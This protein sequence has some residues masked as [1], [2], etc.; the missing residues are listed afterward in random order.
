M[1]LDTLKAQ[2]LSARKQKDAAHTAVLG[3]VIGDVETLAK[4]KPGTDPAVLIAG[5]L[6][7][8]LTALVREREQLAGLGRDTASIDLELP[9]LQQL[10]AQATEAQRQAQA[11]LSAR[12][13]SP[14]ALETAIRIAVTQGAGSIG[15]VM[16][17]LKTQHEGAYDG[18]LASD[19][20]RRVLAEANAAE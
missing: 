11:D 19:T 9:V 17:F 5:V 2:H 13:L 15:A 16:Q 18:K 14:E 10:H 7:D 12:Q 8:Q 6:T 4:N 3:R 1:N 20:T